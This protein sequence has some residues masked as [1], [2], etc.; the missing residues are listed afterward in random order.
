MMG[1][2]IEPEAELG[3]SGLT[4]EK[5]Q[6]AGVYGAHDSGARH[7]S[8]IKNLRGYNNYI[9]SLLLGRFSQKGCV[10]LDICGGK[11]GDITKFVKNGARQ[12]VTADVSLESLKEAATRFNSLT[13]RPPHKLPFHYT[14]VCADCFKP[15]LLS[16][17]DPAVRFDLVSCQFALHYSF[18]SE[19]DAHGLLAN[20][21]A[22]LKPGGY[23]VGTTADANAL[24]KKLMK[25][26]ELE[27]GNSV[28]HVRFE[29]KARP[30][31]FGPRA[32]YWFRLADA[33]DDLPEYLVHFETLQEIAR[34]HGLSCVR[35]FTHK[36]PE[37]YRRYHDAELA[38]RMHVSPLNPDEEEVASLYITFVFQ[39]KGG[40]EFQTPPS[41][42]PARPQPVAPSDI[43]II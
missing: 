36:F 43:I 10:I 14:L 9:K 4:S 40:P 18:A 24:Y 25:A 21:S 31:R 3:A 6:I 15:G 16:V 30:D 12:V 1:D 32:R 22:R 13:E 39:K 17:V 35:E 5:K 8:V 11:G 37:F 34:K 7:E 28:Y 19:E 27:F 23:F 29:S 26:P 38:A 41:N 20:V 42:P 33:V 2:Y